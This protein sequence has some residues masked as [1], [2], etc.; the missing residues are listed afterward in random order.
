MYQEHEEDHRPS[1]L[2]PALARPGPGVACPG[3][4][5]ALGRGAWRGDGVGRARLAGGWCAEGALGTVLAVV[6][7]GGACARG[8]HADA[9][10][11]A[12]GEA[13]AGG[14]RALR[15]VGAGVARGARRAQEAG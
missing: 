5:L 8:V 11:G 13:Y 12:G 7:A 14:V 4:A 3:K 10:Q 6:W 9:A 2:L 1:S 15:A